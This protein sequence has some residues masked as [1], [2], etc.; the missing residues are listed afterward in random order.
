MLTQR[1]LHQIEELVDKKLDEKL[2]E[3]LKY[4]PTTEEFF[5]KM[6]EVMGEVK[7]TR[8][9]F[10]LHAGQHS[11]INDTLEDHEERLKKFEKRQVVAA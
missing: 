11:D 3:K 7:A 10:E 5:S 4:L 6:D 2:D 8:E 1:D 9:A